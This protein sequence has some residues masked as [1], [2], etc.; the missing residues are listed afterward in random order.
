MNALVR[1]LA[2]LIALSVV[3]LPVVAVLN[4]W[5]AVE[6]WPL[7]RLQVKAEF[8]R[9]SAEQVQSAVRPHVG[10]GFFAVDLAA[11]HASLVDL[12]W[13]QEVSVRKVWP[14]TLEISL[15]EHR[16][17]ARFGGERL[18]SD[19][20]D[21]F[22]VPEMDAL[23]G[24]PRFEADEA[25]LR[26]LIEMYRQSQALLG[27]SARIELLE[28]SPRGS[29]SL[30]LASG[31]EILLG[32]T[33]PLV[34]LRRFLAALPELERSEARPLLRADLRYANGFALKWAPAAAAPAGQQT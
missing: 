15:G 34:R 13:V 4:G 23:Q 26:P 17:L 22:V 25:H 8:Q 14:D 33:E 5:I 21:L 1:L 32:R 9:V 19:A 20:G 18:L 10:S 7:T 2:W 29:W 28:Y 24:L 30:R 6:R 16:A 31:T 3:A 12:P 27:P 11:V